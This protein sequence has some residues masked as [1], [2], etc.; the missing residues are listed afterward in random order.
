V[1]TVGTE[2]VVLMACSLKWYK[3]LDSFLAL[4][5][6]FQLDGRAPRRIRFRLLINCSAAAWREFASRNQIPSNVTTVIRPA[7]IYQH[8]GE[9]ALVLNLSHREGWI[10]TFGMTLLEA[11]ASG[12]P[13]VAPVAGGCTELFEDGAGGWHLDSRQ[14]NSIAALIAWLATD[15]SAWLA[16]RRA[17]SASAAQFEPETF[18]AGVRSAVIDPAP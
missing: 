17:T 8:Y 14:L 12:V 9:A 10:E 4:A 2:F 7:D 18:S 16:A 3:G 11:M 13:V 5:A 1:R 6:Q 15:E